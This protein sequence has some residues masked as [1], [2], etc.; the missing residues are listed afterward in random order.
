VTQNINRAMAPREWGMLVL[1]SLLWGG[2]FFFTGVA[3]K[4][5]P[6]LTIVALRVGLAALLLLAIVRA[7]GLRM[8]RSRASW[9]ALC[10]MGLL[11]NVVPF[12]LLV[13]GQTRIASGLA[14][15]LN[16]T[17]PLWTVLVAHALM[18][19]EKLTGRRLAGVALGFAGVVVVVGP[20]AVAGL[21]A[22]LLAQIAC[23]GAAA[24]YA[25]AGVYGR[26]FTRMGLAPMPTA[27]GQVVVS[28]V[29]L[30]PAAIIVDR[31]WT[32]AAPGLPTWAAILGIATLSTALGYIIYFRLLA[33]AGATNLLLVTFLIPVSAVVLGAT[34]LGEQLA[35][36]SF[37]G[38]AL[39]GFG[40][41]AIDGR[42][43]AWRPH[44]RSLRAFAHP[45]RTP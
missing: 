18:P 24:S 41:L 20:D 31:P 27:A 13:W 16:A 8:P 21:Q 38:M 17:T 29:M 25:F 42:A 19:D 22:N 36:W 34:V 30:V 32:L 26:R 5:L 33:S 28:S 3:V 40:L 15:I 23:L 11:N 2:S 12:C 44:G 10:G 6:P 7:M 39:V 4:A 43:F 35:A 45:G 14:A 37:F 1:L 9:T